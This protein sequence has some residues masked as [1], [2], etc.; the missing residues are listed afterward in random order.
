MHYH[1]LE[2]FKQS[3][4]NVTAALE[5]AWIAAAWTSPWRDCEPLRLSHPDAVLRVPSSVAAG[6]HMAGLATLPPEIGS[7]IQR[8]SSDSPLWRYI[9]LSALSRHLSGI[10]ALALTSWP[11]RRIVS[12]RRGEEPVCGPQDS[13]QETEALRLTIDCR[14]LLEIERLDKIPPH[15]RGRSDSLVYAILA[16][17]VDSIDASMHLKVSLSGKL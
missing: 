17:E 12:W 16:D 10:Q 14:G 6:L 8:Y 7:K 5:G 9:A 2:L 3:W 15:K 4:D 1:C 11:L 13:M